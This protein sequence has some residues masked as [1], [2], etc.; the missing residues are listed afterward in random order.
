MVMAEYKSQHLI[1]DNLILEYDGKGIQ[2]EEPK[3]AKPRSLKAR[4]FGWLKGKR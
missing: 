3:G 4:L 2:E 1:R